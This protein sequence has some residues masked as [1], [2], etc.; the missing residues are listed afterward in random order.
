M[1][2][3]TALLGMTS[4]ACHRGRLSLGAVAK[5]EVG[6][7][8]TRRRAQLGFVCCRPLVR[9]QR[10][11][12]RHLRRIYVA[13]AAELPRVTGG[14]RLR[15]FLLTICLSQLS[16]QSE[17]K[18]RSLVR[19]WHRKFGYILPRKAHGASERDVTGCTAAVG[20]GQVCGSDLMAVETAL[21]H[22]E[23]DLHSLATEC[24]ASFAGER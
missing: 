21:H 11:D 12:G 7:L 8:M 14:A 5:N 20:R 4:G 22:R 17:G 2:G 18:T 6:I 1:A 19:G 23:A 13:V 3:E 10:L 9:S 15:D 24:V 16:M